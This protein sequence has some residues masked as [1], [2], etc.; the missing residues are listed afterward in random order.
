MADPA[1][2]QDQ[3]PRRPGGIRLLRPGGTTVT[4]VPDGAVQLPPRGR[5]PGTTDQTRAARPQYPGT[6]GSLTASIGGLLI[7][8]ADRALLTDAG[9]GPSSLPPDPATPRGAIHGGALLDNLAKPGRR[10]Q[11]IEAVAFTH[12]H[13]DHAGWAVHTAPGDKQPAFAHA[14][15]LLTGPEWAQRHHPEQPGLTP[16]IITAPAPR[17][18]RNRR[19]GSLPR[20]ARAHHRRPHTRACRVHPHRGR[21]AA[22]RLRRHPAPPSRPATPSGPQPSTTTPP[23]PPSTAAGL[24]PSWPSPGPPGSASISPTCSSGTSAATAPPRPG[25]RWTPAPTQNKGSS[26]QQAAPRAAIGVTVRR[27]GPSDAAG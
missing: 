23:S 20:P 7:E 26:D 6:S 16:E 15:Y 10:P 18:H 17:A 19:T 1:V 4:Y 14:G 3:R 24:S 22:D 8:T 11:D 12:L 9:S 13:P 5:L 25:S 2:E 27:P 21:T